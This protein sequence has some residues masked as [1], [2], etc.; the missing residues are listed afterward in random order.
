MRTSASTP[1]VIHND[2]VAAAAYPNETSR[3]DRPGRPGRPGDCEMPAIARPAM[4]RPDA[5]DAGR[6][7]Q[8]ASVLQPSDA[9]TA[10]M[11]AGECGLLPAAATSIEARWTPPGVSGGPSAGRPDEAAVMGPATGSLCLALGGRS[12]P[13]AQAT[14]RVPTFGCELGPG[15]AAEP[16]RRPPGRR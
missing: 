14:A 5:T 8:L 3:R 10:D 13:A 11:A 4:T 6:T 16:S 7:A 12:V 15:R 2:R 9:L 1:T